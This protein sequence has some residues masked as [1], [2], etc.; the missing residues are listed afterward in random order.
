M[1]TETDL[2]D[3]SGTVLAEIRPSGM[4]RGFAV[5]VLGA[6]AVLQV[7]SALVNPPSAVLGVVFLLVSGGCALAL[8]MA[9]YRVT[10]VRLVLT[11][12]ALMEET[13][14]ILAPVDRIATVDRGLFAFKPSNGFLVHLTEPAPRHWAPGLWWRWG[15]RIG[16]GGVTVAAESRAMADV[17]S[18]L[19]AS[20]DG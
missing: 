13:G 16:V 6:L 18:A 20:R 7:W 5:M 2:S 4:R 10:A 19:L 3:S 17:L 9:M 8:A 1:D 14:R 15:R 12:T 11:E